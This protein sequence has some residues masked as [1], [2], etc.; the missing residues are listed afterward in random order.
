MKWINI[1]HLYQPPTQSKEIVDQVVKESY[2]KIISLLDQYPILRLTMNVAGSLLELLRKY[3]HENIITGLK[4]HVDR[5]VIELLGSAMYHPILPLLSASMIRRQIKLHD[6]ISKECFGKACAPRGFYFPEM[7]YSRESAEVVKAAG[8]EWTTLDE[9]HS[10]E[11]IIW[12]QP[13]TIKNVGL[14]VIFRNSHFS[15]S[16]P[17]ESIVAELGSIT[18]EYVITCHDGEMYGHWH[19][20]DRGFYEKAFSHPRIGFLTASEYVDQEDKNS[21]G[22]IDEKNELDIRDASWESQPDELAKNIPLGLWN[23]PNND[24]HQL[25][26]SLKRKVLT[27][28]DEHQD[29]PGFV[30]ARHHSD[31]GVASCAWWWASERK[32]GPFSPITWNPTEIEKGAR[33]LETAYK[34]LQ[35]VDPTE[36]K[37]IGEAFEHLFKRIW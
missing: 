25:L 5:G 34:S 22:K 1:L 8:F 33:E 12:S 4:R 29:D 17:P 18:E 16:F 23:D 9:I 30:T 27:A 26:E 32:L 15:K 35:T 14:G 6:D 10:V 3:G 2:S 31:R 19:R 24:I 36:A 28:I 7:A 11:K 21:D 37:E 20:D 13:Y